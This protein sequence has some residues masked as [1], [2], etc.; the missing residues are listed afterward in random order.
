MTSSVKVTA[1]CG[2]GKQVR[3]QQK[4]MQT[5]ANL[6]ADVILQN[7]ESREEYVHDAIVI[8]VNEEDK[9]STQ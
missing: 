5:G 6:N 8:T 1:L 4:H 9:P 7:G 2:N 3:I